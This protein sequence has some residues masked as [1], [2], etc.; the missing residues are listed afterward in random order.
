MSVKEKKKKKIQTGSHKKIRKTELSCMT[1]P[2]K[3]DFVFSTPVTLHADTHPH[4]RGCTHTHTDTHPTTSQQQGQPGFCLPNILPVL[5]P[6]VCAVQPN[7]Q[8]RRNHKMDRSN[9]TSSESL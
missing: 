7:T 2:K 1:V 9:H 3:N 8:E 6:L 4:K 5:R